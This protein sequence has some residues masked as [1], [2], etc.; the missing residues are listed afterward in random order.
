M[1]GRENNKLVLGLPTGSL[2]E[3]TFN[4]FEKAGFRIRTTGRSYFPTIND[5]DIEVVLLRAQEI[6][7]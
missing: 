1:N 3:A 2:Q 7:V 6:P 4:M 5:D